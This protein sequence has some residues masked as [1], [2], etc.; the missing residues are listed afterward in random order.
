MTQ[1][2]TISKK[3]WKLYSLTSIT[4]HFA[5]CDCGIGGNCQSNGNCQCETGYQLNGLKCTDCVSGYEKSEN[6]GTCK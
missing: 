5:V 6:D 3:F 1:F 2:F 4:L